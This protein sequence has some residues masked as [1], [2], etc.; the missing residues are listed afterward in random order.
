MRRDKLADTAAALAALPPDS[1]HEEP[2]RES[3]SQICATR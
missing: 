1:L 2:L 3:P